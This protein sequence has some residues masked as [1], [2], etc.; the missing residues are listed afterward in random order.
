[1]TFF[2]VGLPHFLVLA[3]TLFCVGFYGLLTR[4][5]A[6]ALLM[7]AEL[8]LNAVNINLVAINRFLHP[9]ALTGQVYAL[10]IITVAAAEITVGLALVVSIYR[11]RRC[12][13]A[14]DIN[15]LKG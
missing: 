10:F 2:P 14:E 4:R 15:F 6:V 5:N 12:V 8:M 9:Q 1:M 13:L 3:A 11:S 7:S